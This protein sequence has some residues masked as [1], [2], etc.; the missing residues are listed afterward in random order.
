MARCNQKITTEIEQYII[1]NYHSIGCYKLAKEL[2]VHPKTIYRWAK[3]YNLPGLTRKFTAKYIERSCAKCSKKFIRSEKSLSKV[4]STYCSRE[5]FI[6]DKNHP[7]ILNSKTKQ[8]L[9]LINQ[10]LTHKEISKLTG[11]KM[12][13][14][15]SCLNRALYR[16]Q[17]GCSFPTIRKKFLLNKSCQICG[18]DRIVEAAHIIP[19]S[20]KG[21]NTFDNLL[22]LCPNHHHLFDHNRLE[23]NE[24]KLIQEQVEYAIRKYKNV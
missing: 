6:T 3:K 18:F 15:A 14:I 16:N 9:D 21:L 10:G 1:D 11:F 17:P 23:E 8:I 22:A 7:K 20:K 5:C 24:F 13:S 4:Q 12:G 2:N 19:V